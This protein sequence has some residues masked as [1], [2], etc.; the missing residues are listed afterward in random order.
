MM[1]I[2]APGTVKRGDALKGVAEIDDGELDDARK[3]E[4]VLYNILT[5]GEGKKNYSAWE[6]KKSF[7]AKDAKALFELPFEFAVDG[8]APVTYRG[9]QLLS[10]WR[11]ALRVD[12]AGKL[13]NRTEREIV[14]MR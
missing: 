8:G 9:R 10:K 2:K 1:T 5:F 14:V 7:S 13:D 11:L 3:V 4:I 12:I 6:M